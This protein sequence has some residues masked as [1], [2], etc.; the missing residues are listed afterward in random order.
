MS[1]VQTVKIMWTGEMQNDTYLEELKIF[2]GVLCG[3]IAKNDLI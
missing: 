1:D 2:C 3:V